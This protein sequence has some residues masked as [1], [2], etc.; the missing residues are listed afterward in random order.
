[1]NTF[2]EMISVQLEFSIGAVERRDEFDQIAVFNLPH[3][4]WRSWEFGDLWYKSGV[5]KTRILSHSL[6][7]TH[8]LTHTHSLS[9]TLTHTN[10]LTLTYSHSHSHSLTHSAPLQA[11]RD[12][13]SPQHPLRGVPLLTPN[14]QPPTPNPKP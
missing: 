3:L 6:S 11:L 4:Y 10:A 14:P 1:M 7:L 12:V 2:C 8:S 9:L 5:S 13:Q